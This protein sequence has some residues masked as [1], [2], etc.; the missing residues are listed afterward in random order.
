MSQ[1]E[2][3]SPTDNPPNDPI[4][5]QECGDVPANRVRSASPDSTESTSSV[6]ENDE[7]HNKTLSVHSLSRHTAKPNMED[8]ITEKTIAEV[9]P[10][11]ALAEKH[12]PV[13]NPK[14]NPDFFDPDN[15]HFFIKNLDAPEHRIRVDEYVPQQMSAHPLNAEVE[16]RGIEVTHLTEK[17]K[18]KQESEEKKLQEASD[19]ERK[20][21]KKKKG[22]SK[23]DAKQK[24][25]YIPPCLERTKLSL[26]R[27]T[28]KDFRGL[29][30]VQTIIHPADT[31]WCACATPECD[32]ICVGGLESVIRVY[33]RSNPLS[34]LPPTS[35][36]P[37][38][39][40]FYKIVNDQPILELREHTN[41]ILQLSTAPRGFILSAS[42][43]CT[44][45]LW[46]V[47]RPNSLRT[48]PHQDVVTSCDFNPEDNGYCVTG[49]LD[50]KVRMWNVRNGNVLYRTDVGDLVTAVQFSPDATMVL[51]GTFTGK[52]YVLTAVGLE[53]HTRIDVRSRRG[54]NHDKK[55]TGIK[56]LPEGDA[57]LVTSNDSRIRCYTCPHF[58][59]TTKYIGMANQV[60][61]LTASSS[62]N[63]EFVISGSENG[64]CYIWDRY[65]RYIPAV[66]PAFTR[67]R[68][69]HIETAQF[70][71]AHDENCTNAFFLNEPS[72]PR[73]NRR[74]SM[75]VAG[76]ETM[77]D[78]SGAILI[79]TGGKGEL[80]LW[81]R[82][83][84]AYTE[85]IQRMVQEA[86]EKEEEQPPQN[87]EELSPPK[88]EEQSTAQDTSTPHS[89]S[90]QTSPT[91]DAAQED[92]QPAPSE[93]PNT[94]P[95]A[96]AST[97]SVEQEP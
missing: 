67:H 31:L 43:D 56:F 46:H 49:C 93:S 15:P 6:N 53:L 32:Y 48:F 44:A 1:P 17:E 34:F 37:T 27:S 52:L 70:F 40:N 13:P 58:E 28:N 33:S 18:K 65:P 64:N 66:N 29:C 60:S 11:I 81:R 63:D 78:V 97:Q 54:R 25:A 30:R 68:R 55:I 94:Q 23:A 14:E 41:Q 80:S 76:Q 26:R 42:V 50:R 96:L 47:S 92:I 59:Q 39:P 10:E 84:E 57:F 62:M 73:T 74:K 71:K 35:I 87:E 85:S 77:E 4:D 88:E 24:D 61:Q 36:I 3:G 38:D 8:T 75:T 7:H 89:P 51:V 95:S 21:I 79:T 91:E 69:D 22:S 9:Q 19:K 86:H 72:R 12:K 16:K 45:K 82:F 2:E 20:K 83:D 5:H 90:P